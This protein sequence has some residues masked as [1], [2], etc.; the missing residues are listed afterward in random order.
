MDWRLHQDEAEIRLEYTVISPYTNQRETRVARWVV[1]RKG[2]P[3]QAW[4]LVNE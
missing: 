2:A 1:V 3:N 4:E